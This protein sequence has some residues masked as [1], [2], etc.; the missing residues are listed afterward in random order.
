ML[1]VL[2]QVDDLEFHGHE[3]SMFNECGK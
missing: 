1:F 3:F 2:F